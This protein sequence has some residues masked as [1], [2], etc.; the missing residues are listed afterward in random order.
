MPGTTVT[1]L[2]TA[3]PRRVVLLDDE[4][5]VLRDLAGMLTRAGHAVIRACAT[6]AQAGE[7]LRELPR[8]DLLIADLFLGD[9]PAGLEAYR[10]AERLGIPYFAFTGYPASDALAHLTGARPLGLLYKPLDYEDVVTRIELA[11][12]R[13]EGVP[14]VATVSFRAGRRTVVLAEDDLLCVESQ[15]NYCLARADGDRVHRIRQTLTDFAEDLPPGR[16]LRVHR[17]FVVNLARVIAYGYDHAYLSELLRV[18]VGR[19]YRG[20]FAACMRERLREH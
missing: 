5:I 15:G 2:R 6:V 19:S 1:G 20:G 13:R 14:G 10:A 3:A 18:P 7:A 4:A 8:P 11:F 12:R 9:R 17:S 16:F